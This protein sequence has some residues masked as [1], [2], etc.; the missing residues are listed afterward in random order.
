MKRTKANIKDPLFRF[1]E[2]EVNLGAK[3][4][5]DVRHD[6]VE[7]LAV[8]KGE[9]KQSNNIRI[10]ITA[11]TKAVIPQSWSRYPL[12]STILTVHEWMQDYVERVKQLV[13]LAASENHRS[14]EVWLGGM[15]FPEAYITATRQLI[16]QTNGWSL[17]QLNMHVRLV[18]NDSPRESA[19]FAIKGFTPDFNFLIQLYA[20]YIFRIPSN[21]S[22]L[23]IAQSDS[24]H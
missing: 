7:I 9:Q 12:P 14:E 13:R 21:R 1:F 19:N 2:R 20:L 10:L 11:L 6:L 17:E 22:C 24:N 3:L 16:A 15:F 23:Q 4:L 5:V 18:D 8:C